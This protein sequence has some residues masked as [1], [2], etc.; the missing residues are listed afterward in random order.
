MNPYEVYRTYSALRLH[1]TNSQYDFFK[2]KGECGINVARFNNLNDFE[3]RQMLRVSTEK[4]P[5][6]YLVGNF[7][8]NKEN[9][10]K[11]FEQKPYLVYRSYLTN[12]EYIFSQE[13]GNLKEPFADN[14]IVEN[15][16]IPH[17]IYLIN[18]GKIS[19]FSAC[20]LQQLVNWTDKIIDNVV[21][22]TQAEKINK[23][24][25]FFKIDQTNVK[26]ILLD[27]YKINR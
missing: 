3:R 26:K 7:L 1:F 9:Y 21:L 18:E 19:L 17:I 14:F 4:E 24:Y 13:I 23:S 15:G 27:R 8:F 6:T 10:I 12:G 16:Q 5:K 2:Y 20:V 25:K 22:Q 11:F